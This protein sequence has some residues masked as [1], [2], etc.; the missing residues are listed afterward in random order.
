MQRTLLVTGAAGMLGR[1][2]LRRPPEGWT[3]RLTDVVLPPSP[4][5]GWRTL[6]VTDP[7]ATAAACEGVDAVL[8]LGGI[9][10]NVAETRDRLI[11]VNVGGTRNLLDAAT[12]AGV[13]RVL[14]ASSNHAVG[15]HAR[16]PGG[17]MLPDDVPCRPDSLYGVT[18]AAMESLGCYYAD[19]HG[20]EVVLLRIGSC[21]ER[22][23]SAR[24]LATWLSPGD[25]CRLVGAALQAAV[26]GCVPVWG[27]SANTRRWWSAEGGA[28]LGYHPLDDAE[29]F[30]PTLPPSP[31]A[32]TPETVGGT[33]PQRRPSP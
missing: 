20:T 22:P 11:P 12:A 21:F 31:P 14:L 5:P 29:P 28:A 9:A 16:P 33:L 10:N 19:R 23:T 18:K 1:F 30:A 6:D 3:L 13:R 26:T 27:V 2:L 17:R 7:A 4:P 32:P 8:H 15:F 25:F 24:M